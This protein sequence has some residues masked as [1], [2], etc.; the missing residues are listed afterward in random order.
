M[1]RRETP[2]QQ[3]HY[4]HIYNRGNNRAPIFFEKENYLFF[5]KRWRKYVCPC[6][7]VIAYCLMPTHYHF[8]VRVHR[9]QTSEVFKTSEVS[10]IS[11]EAPNLSRAMQKFS[12]SYTK[13]INKRFE[14][15]GALFQGAFHAKIVETQTHLLHL[16]RYI[17]AN[18]V[19]D[20]LVA[21]PG[22]W[23]YSNYLEWIAERDGT[24]VDRSFV[25]ENFN[26]PLEYI[27]FVNDYLKTRHLP[28]DIKR[29]LNA[30]E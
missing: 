23:P 18:P 1:P 12:I 27:Q 25:R 29:Y 5:L 9:N 6:V 8:L 4:Y 21:A 3:D 19:K 20:E 10:E 14:R 7:D 11:T 28:E 26:T 24:M 22:D 17:H 16:C 15:V 2:L 30:L 13:A